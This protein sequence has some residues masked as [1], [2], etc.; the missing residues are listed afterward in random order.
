MCILALCQHKC[1]FSHESFAF[2]IHSFFLHI[3]FSSTRLLLL[4][5]PSTLARI[6][7]LL[8]TSLTLP[9]FILVNFITDSKFY[10]SI[11]FPFDSAWVDLLSFF[12]VVSS[13]LLLLLF[14]FSLSFCSCARTCVRIGFHQTKSNFVIA[15][16]HSA[17]VIYGD[18]SNRQHQ[19]DA[20]NFCYS[21]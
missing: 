20:D 21:E 19:F 3:F 6:I 12:F 7:V 17:M 1:F 2:L 11:V 10:C 14:Y 4:V 13:F 5:L 18:C 9:L 15:R 8:H 16:S